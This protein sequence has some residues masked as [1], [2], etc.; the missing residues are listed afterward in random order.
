MKQN[1]GKTFQ[2]IVNA[3]SIVQHV[4]EVKHEIIILVNTCVKK[5]FTCKKIIVGIVAH[6]FMRIVVV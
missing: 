4:T 3:N 5:Y 2:M 6:V 1:I